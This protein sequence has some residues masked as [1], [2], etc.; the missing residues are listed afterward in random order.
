MKSFVFATYVAFL[1]SMAGLLALV[2][3]MIWSG[4]GLSLLQQNL[5]ASCAA[6][7]ASAVFLIAATTAIL[8]IQR[9]LGAR[10]DPS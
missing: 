7:A 1:L 3:V 2:L 8:R 10:R 5:L 6:V 4:G 9:E